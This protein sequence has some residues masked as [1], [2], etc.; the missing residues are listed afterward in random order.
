MGASKVYVVKAVRDVCGVTLVEANKLCSSAPVVIATDMTQSEAEAIAAAIESAGGSVQVN[1]PLN[2]PKAIQA[3][4]TR[5]YEVVL[6][7]LGA[8]KA[9]V[10]KAVRDV[11]GVTLVEAKKLCSSAPVVIATDKTLTEAQAIEGAIESE[12]GSVQ[13]NAPK[14]A[15]KSEFNVV[16]TSVGTNRLN[17]VKAVMNACGLGLGAANDLTKNLPAVIATGVSS[18]DAQAIRTAIENAGGAV[19]IE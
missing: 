4:E 5:G 12:G 15:Q 3:D 7:D 1:A 16:L 10:V 2:A 17:V 19:R 14:N 6:L 8:S 13:V 11:C 9:N 18:S